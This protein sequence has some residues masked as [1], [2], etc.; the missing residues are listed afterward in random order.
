MAMPS[1][2]TKGNWSQSEINANF[3]P[4]FEGRSKTLY[5]TYDPLEGA[6]KKNFNFTGKERNIETHLSFAGGFGSR[7]LPKGKQ[8]CDGKPKDHI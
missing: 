7:L 4:T 6:I 1:S 5:S 3:K 8:L 2:S